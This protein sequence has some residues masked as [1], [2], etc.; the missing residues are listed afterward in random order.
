MKKAVGVEPNNIFTYREYPSPKATGWASRLPEMLIA[1]VQIGIEPTTKREITDELRDV[2]LRTAPLVEQLR[3]IKTQA[4]I[5]MIRRSAR[6]ADYGVERLLSASYYGAMV[7][8]GFAETRTV[9]AKIIR[10]VENWD[11]LTTK[12][13]MATWTA[14]RSAMPHSVPTLQD[15]LNVGP[16]VA[17]VLS[18]VNEGLASST[19]ATTSES[20]SVSGEASLGWSPVSRFSVCNSRSQDGE[21]RSISTRLAERDSQLF[22]VIDL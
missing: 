1:R 15:Q 3:V 11:A 13:L 10:E 18:R 14:P 12:V 17:L 5:A 19:F 16:H 4:E 6:Y 21:Y 22:H 8:E 9:S 2:S 20:T 7:A